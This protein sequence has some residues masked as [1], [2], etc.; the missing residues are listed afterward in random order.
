MCP[1]HRKSRT[2]CLTP[3][4]LYYLP[5]EINRSKK[6]HWRLLV[7]AIQRD[8]ISGCR[9]MPVHRFKLDQPS[10]DRCN[11]TACLRKAVACEELHHQCDTP[12]QG[13]N[14]R[15]DLF[16]WP[17]D[18]SP[19][20]PPGTNTI[21][22]G[23]LFPSGS[24]RQTAL[25]DISCQLE[26]PHNTNAFRFCEHHFHLDTMIDGIYGAVPAGTI[27]VD[28]DQKNDQLGEPAQHIVRREHPGRLQAR[29]TDDIR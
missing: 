17:P 25:T 24:S 27:P 16:Q 26:N 4:W 9:T 6:G 7:K 13:R 29:G 11:T 15:R 8:G 23:L 5:D 2:V 28:Q 3:R 19:G 22:Q 20:S 18:E 14:S 1:E 12:R 21:Y 10:A